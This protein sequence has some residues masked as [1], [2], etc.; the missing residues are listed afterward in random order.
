MFVSSGPSRSKSLSFL[1]VPA[2]AVEAIESAGEIAPL[3]SIR[4]AGRT[5]FALAVDGRG[6]GGRMLF[7][8]EGATGA[9]RGIPAI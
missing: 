1:F 7:F 5:E 4:L 2:V 6:R 3:R 9:G 8:L